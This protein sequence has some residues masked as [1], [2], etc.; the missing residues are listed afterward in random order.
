MSVQTNKICQRVPVGRTGSW[1]HPLGDRQGFSLL[2]LLIVIAL[3]VTMYVLYLSAGSQNFQ[4]KQKQACRKNLQ[5]TYMA[6][7][8]YS[9]ETADQFPMVADAARSEEALGFLVPRYTTVTESF[10]CPGTKDKPPAAARDFSNSKI[11][12]AYYMGRNSLQGSQMPLMSDEQVDT[13][14]K[15]V[16]Q[17]LFSAD[18]K[19]RGNNH[20]KYGGVILFCDGSAQLSGT[21]TSVALPLGSGVTLLNPKR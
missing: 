5:N 14:A 19:G 9:I 3:L 18:G 16:G 8:T 7:K 17:L 11:S 13:Q 20:N 4:A 21:N 15:P 6:L 12:Y 10:I 1:M 2:E